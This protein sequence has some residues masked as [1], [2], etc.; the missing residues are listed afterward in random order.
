MDWNGAD[1]HEVYYDN[2]E[3]GYR[4][5]FAVDLKSHSC[6]CRRWDVSGIPC[7]H[8]LAAIAYEGK[9]PID[10][11]DACYSKEVY[12]KAY[13]QLLH[14]V[15]GPMF[16]PEGDMEPVLPP[17]VNKPKGR[18]QTQRIREALEGRKAT[19]KMSRIGRKMHC[20][21]CK[22][23]GHNKTGCRSKV[24]VNRL[25][26]LYYI[27]VVMLCKFCVRLGLLLHVSGKEQA[28]RKGKQW[29]AVKAHNRKENRKHEAA[30]K[31][32]TKVLKPEGVNKKV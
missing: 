23:A 22:Q 16:W 18:R 6:S 7:A 9:D 13:E 27:L 5:S 8:A 30:N 21:I 24:S 10:F 3:A 32:R 19:G 20:S 31:S 28:T 2:A 25:Q 11:L 15:K 4:E 26:I 14:P 1:K 29:R 12:L 17:K